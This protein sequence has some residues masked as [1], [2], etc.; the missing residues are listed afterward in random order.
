MS[1][2][3]E[4]VPARAVGPIV[5]AAV[6]AVDGVALDTTLQAISRQ[7]YEP[8]SV[9]VIASEPVTRE[10]VLSAQSLAKLVQSLDPSVE[11]VWL[12]HGDAEPRPDA[13]ASLVAET[14]RSD[15]ALVGSKILDATHRDRLENVGGASD[16]FGEPYFGLDEDE[17]DLEQYD[18]VRDV[19]HVSA[20]SLLI[21]RDLLRGLQGIDPLLA[22]GAA[23]IDLSQ[24]A[25]LAGARVMVVPS[26]EVFHAR[27]CRHEVADWREQA[28]RMRS[29]FKAYRLV[30]LLWVVPMGFT[31]A[32]IDGLARFGLRQFRPLFDYLRALGWNLIH[33]LSTV[34][35]RRA[36]RPVRVTGD[37]ELF[38]YQVAGS[39]RM[40]N[41]LTD[42]GE[43]YGWIIDREP[44]VVTEEEMDDDTKMV[45]TL[46]LAF[47]LF[48]VALVTR[49]LWWS[50]DWLSGFWLPLGEHPWRT[51]V[52]YA[53][54]WNPAGLGSPEPVPPV[55]A[56]LSLLQGVL[57]GWSGARAVAVVLSAG[58]AVLGLGR[59]L[60]YFG[61]AGPSRHLAG[62]VF[63]TGPLALALGRTGHWE[64]L[65]AF[66]PLVWSLVWTVEPRRL[67]GR[68][69]RLVLAGM[70]GVAGTL[71]FPVLYVVATV[72]GGLVLKV[73]WRS[74]VSGV[75]FVVAGAVAAM[76]PH[77][78]AIGMDTLTRGSVVIETTTVVALAGVTAIVLTIVAGSERA[79]RVAAWGG[80][81][82]LAGGLV[83]RIA[84]I[85]RPGQAAG[86]LLASLGL[87]AAVGAAFSR[88]DEASRG[89]RGL[90]ILAAAAAATVLV[91]GARGVVDGSW[92]LVDTDWADRLEFVSALSDDAEM[93]RTLL[94]GPA[95]S[96]VGDTRSADG[97]SYRLMNGAAFEL[98]EAWLP[99]A[100]AGDRALADALE[101]VSAGGVLRP[102]G[103]LA[104]FAIRW[105]VLVGDDVW[106]GA[107]D[108]QL[109]IREVSVAPG[110]R[111]F[112]NMSSAPRVLANTSG[113]SG[114]GG[115]YSGPP[116]DH[117]RLADNRDAGWGGTAEE[118]ANSIPAASGVIEYSPDPRRLG[119]GIL[120]ALT[121]LG[122]LVAIWIGRNP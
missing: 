70:L 102:G 89:R 54:G 9:F 81:L 1:I 118:W 11:F 67:V 69:G 121:L 32:L 23:G 64:I 6:V 43:R 78:S 111:V 59:L 107:F 56:G 35:A 36:L 93:E 48:I 27:E 88:D 33:L 5:V 55:V 103:E 44:G 82:A 58:L 57:L 30:T 12:V 53:G 114:G 10:G 39:I 68:A 15:A 14:V 104:P 8:E 85:G 20:V 4:E 51:V 112:E 71:F 65:L 119:L 63:A 22:P 7:A 86:A 18:V 29:M 99:E 108:G 95:G 96:L 41:L 80:V 109:D 24:R 72:L 47:S 3:L 117:V 87:G 94:V 97:F 21:R 26:S 91:V 42:Y 122:S 79:W 100:R 110:V 120:A 37:E 106:P 45:S 31:I 49:R 66:A 105:I 2:P 60:A 52:S 16:V 84:D 17:V 28:S 101:Q 40:R 25:R 90:E 61:V 115:S 50:S 46:L 75:A 74:I 73:R 92:G 76:A 77:L 83:A 62:L 34:G 98:D 38:R 13:L 19:G 116:Q 113:W